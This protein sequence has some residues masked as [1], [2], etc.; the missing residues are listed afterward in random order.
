[1]M[2]YY[3]PDAGAVIVADREQVIVNP[4]VAHALGL[5]MVYQHFTLVS[6]MTVTENLVLARDQLPAVIDCTPNQAT[7]AMMAAPPAPIAASPN[8]TSNPAAR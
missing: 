1:M 2:G 8:V 3:Q 6:A 7:R 4:R 5:G